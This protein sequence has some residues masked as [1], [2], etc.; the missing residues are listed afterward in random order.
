MDQTRL[1]RQIHG[2]IIRERARLRA[3]GEKSRPTLSRIC[4]CCCRGVCVFSIRAIDV[5]YLAAFIFQT[6]VRARTLRKEICILRR[7]RSSQIEKRSLHFRWWKYVTLNNSAASPNRSRH[8][9]SL[10]WHTH[11]CVIVAILCRSARA[12]YRSRSSLFP[13]FLPSN[14][15]VCLYCARQR[16]PH[17]GHIMPLF[18]LPLAAVSTVVVIQVVRTRTGN[19]R[20]NW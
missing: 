9:R 15:S 11:T 10:K 14:E 18:F 16:F 3:R 19:L 5:R 12:S 2:R 13:F 7:A 1:I 20:G 17:V 8:I 4:P 6:R